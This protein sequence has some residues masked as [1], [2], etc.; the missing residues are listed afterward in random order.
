MLQKM[1]RWLYPAGHLIIIERL[2]HFK[3]MLEGGQ[4]L[5]PLIP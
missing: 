3:M 1:A 4:G 2:G 5:A